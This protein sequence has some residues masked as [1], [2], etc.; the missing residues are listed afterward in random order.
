[1]SD[2][3]TDRRKFRLLNVIDDYNRESLAIE[4]DTSLPSQRVIR[5][6]ESIIARRGKPSNLRCDNGP[7]FISHKV[8]QWCEKHRITIQFIQPGRPMQMHTS[9]ETMAVLGANF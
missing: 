5:T 8:E 3:L 7:E 4:V 6:L 9:N 2:A 1:M